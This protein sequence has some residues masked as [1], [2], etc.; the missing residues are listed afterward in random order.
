MDLKLVTIVEMKSYA[1]ARKIFVKSTVLD[2]Y[3]Y[4]LF[5]MRQDAWKNKLFHVIT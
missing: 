2:L 1:I 4:M 5:S 3:V